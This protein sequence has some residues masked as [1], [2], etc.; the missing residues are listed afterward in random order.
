MPFVLNKCYFGAWCSE[1]SSSQILQSVLEPLTM[2][3]LRGWEGLHAPLHL[4]TETLL[5][6]TLDN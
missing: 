6:K 3:E 2:S 1:Y 5:L 4:A